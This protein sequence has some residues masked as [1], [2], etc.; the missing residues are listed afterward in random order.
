[1]RVLCSMIVA[2]AILVALVPSPALA[3]L[4]V[5][6]IAGEPTGFSLKWWNEGG[7]AVDAATGWSLRDEHFYAHCDY[8]W[9]RTIKAESI[10]RGF[11]LYYGVGARVVLHEHSDATVGVR[12]PVGLD[13]MFDNGRV[14]M[15]VEIAPVFNVA[16]EADVD[17]S[18]GVG[19]RFYF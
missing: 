14:D 2:A 1:M 7:T 17:L 12:L 11:P 16:P 3:N 10:G 13:Y 6:V 15:F 19:V 18:G 5:G 8:L 4:G 9:H